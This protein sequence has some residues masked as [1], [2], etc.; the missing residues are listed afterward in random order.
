[1]QKPACRWATRTYGDKQWEFKQWEFKQSAQQ[2][3]R[4]SSGESAGGSRPC[5]SSHATHEGQHA[6]HEGPCSKPHSSTI[7][8]YTTAAKRSDSSTATTTYACFISHGRT[9]PIRRHQHHRASHLSRTSTASSTSPMDGG[10]S[11]RV[12]GEHIRKVRPRNEKTSRVDSAYSWQG[13]HQA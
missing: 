5:K 9:Y 4:R 12:H 10:V 8:D 13:G 6:T 3:T 2:D 11:H 7:D 1:M